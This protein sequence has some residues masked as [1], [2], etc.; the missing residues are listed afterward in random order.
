MDYEKKY[1]EALGWMQSLYEGLHGA[2]KDD[3]EHYFPELKESED[4]RI[5]KALLEL[6]HDT[7]GDGLWIDYNVHKEE[8]LAW[9]EKQGTPKKVSIWKHWKDGIAGNG[10]G[11]P[12]YLVKNGYTYSLSSCLGYECDY[13][14]LS[15]L[16]KLMLEKQGEQILANSA[17]TCKDEQKPQRMISAEAK[18]VLYDKP[19]WSEEDEC[20]MAECINAIATK[21]GW[22]FE[23]KRKTKHW[24]KSLKYRYTWKPSETQLA[25]LSDAV[26][27]YGSEGFSV[28]LLKELLEELKKL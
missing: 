3:A 2:T 11:K 14:E 8:A 27:Y 5:R 20:Y 22:S 13:I 15:E 21:D 1:K 16:D 28:D 18:E 6:V 10:E 7:T 26:K 17:K 23:E 25:C 19:A 9:L 12:I 24:L 4:E